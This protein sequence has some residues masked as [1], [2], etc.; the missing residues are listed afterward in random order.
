MEFR[1]QHHLGIED[2]AA[3]LAVDPNGKRPSF[4]ICGSDVG[5]DPAKIAL[6]RCNRAIRRRPPFRLHNPENLAWPIAQSLEK[7]IHTASSYGIVAD[8]IY[9]IGDRLFFFDDGRFFTDTSFYPNPGDI[10]RMLKKNNGRLYH[11]ERNDGDWKIRPMVRKILEIDEPTAFI[12][13]AEPSNYGSYLFRILPKLMS[14]RNESDRK[15]CVLARSPWQL[16]LL[17]LAGL[18]RSRIIPHKLIAI[19][20]FKDVLLPSMRNRNCYV[21][22]DSKAFYRKIALS[23]KRSSLYPTKLFISRLNSDGSVRSKRAFLAETDLIERLSHFGYQAVRPETF[24]LS[25][26]VALFAGATHIIGG[27]GSGMFN[28]LFADVGVTV[29][30]IESEPHWIG[31]HANLFASCGAHYAFAIG[32]PS[33]QDQRPAHRN[34]SL[35]IDDFIEAFKDVL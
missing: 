12:G 33:E 11:V 34:W 19:T 25:E 13:S 22:D 18:D 16:E 28:V 1:L 2:L 6:F 17:A 15:V 8:H 27:S 7:T 20:R 9:C 35:N 14:L 10:E 24:S 26:Q 4:R 21:D 3:H 31:A 30:D 32:A 23:C 5:D 29:I